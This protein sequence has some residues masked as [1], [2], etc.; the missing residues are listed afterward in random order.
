MNFQEYL[1]SKG[2]EK[3]FLDYSVN[4]TNPPKIYC[5][6]SFVTSYGPTEY[7]FEHSNYPDIVLWW[8]LWM[9]NKPP[10]FSLSRITYVAMTK[11]DE[12]IPDQDLWYNTLKLFNNDVVYNLI[13]TGGEINVKNNLLYLTL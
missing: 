4:R 9:T 7:C 8:G 1:I 10:V 12:H 11:E 6:S 5:D 3:Y 13:L 2:W